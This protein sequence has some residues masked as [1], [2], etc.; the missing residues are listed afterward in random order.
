[1]SITFD[2][3]SE[4]SGGYQWIGT[5]PKSILIGLFSCPVRSDQLQNDHHSSIALTGADLNHSGIS[6]VPARILGS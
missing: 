4:K 1:M 5:H 3:S 2:T 6:A